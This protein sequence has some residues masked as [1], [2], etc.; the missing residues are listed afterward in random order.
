MIARNARRL[1]K[2]SEEILDVA[3]IESNSL[4]L[5]KSG[6]NLK[7]VLTLLIEDCKKQIQLDGREVKILYPQPDDIEV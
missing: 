7:D 2:L 3:R 4:V 1:Q 6:F 5:H